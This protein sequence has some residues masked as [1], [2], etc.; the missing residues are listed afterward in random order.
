LI[1]RFGLIFATAIAMSLVCAAMALAQ[2]DEQNQQAPASEEF[3]ED[4]SSLEAGDPIPGSYIIVLEDEVDNPASVADD[5]SGELGLDPSNVY[6]EAVEGFA[7]EVPAGELSELRADPRVEAVVQDRVIE[8]AA[9]S[10]PTGIKRVDAEA[11]STLAGNGSGAVDADIAILDSGI[12]KGHPDLN[13]AGGTNC[14][15][16]KRTAYSD[17]DGHG[18]H[19]AGAA[20]ARDNDFGVVGV[21]PGARLWAVKVLNNNGSG[22]IN[23]LICGIDWVTG[24]NTDGNA[25]NDIEVANMSLGATVSGAE[26]GRCGWKRDRSIALLHRAVC[27][28]FDAGVLYAAAAGNA[29]DYFNKDVPAAFDQVLAVTGMADFNGE[30]GG[31]APPTCERDGDDT[32][33]NFSNYAKI[34]SADAQHAIAAPSVCIK[35]TW[36]YG[37]YKTISGTSMASPHV[38]GTAALC[39]ATSGTTGKCT[40][41]PTDVMGDL[42]TDAKEKTGNDRLVENYYGFKGDP[43]EKIR[44]RYY[45]YLVYAGGY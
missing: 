32:A 39:I 12:F 10:R 42:R 16:G 5:L 29:R 41:G 7:A 9:Q 20:A 25:A 18:T 8:A 13:I 17:G 15:G 45:G 26:K 1:R 4:A 44:D 33:D 36:K 34:G 43:N 38:G 30:P 23:T 35:S 6:D 11:S 14:T 24:R 31:S 37:G 2:E 19:V 27:D 28:S 40:G 3:V 21:A 22:T